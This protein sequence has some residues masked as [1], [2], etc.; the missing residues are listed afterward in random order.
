[1]PRVQIGQ[2]NGRICLHGVLD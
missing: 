1:L 2:H